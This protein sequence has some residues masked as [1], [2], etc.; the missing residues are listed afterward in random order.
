MTKRDVDS[1][2]VFW[3]S[4]GAADDVEHAE[5]VWEVDTVL[6]WPARMRTRPTFAQF[7]CSREFFDWIAG[8]DGY[9]CDLNPSSG[10]TIASTLK[11]SAKSGPERMTT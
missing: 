5:V 3:R 10:G 1:L 8:G 4:A 11:P 9:L 7:S 6:A 2:T